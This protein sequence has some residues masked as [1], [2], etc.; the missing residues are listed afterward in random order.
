VAIRTAII[1]YG[2]AGRIFHAPLVQAAEGLE[3][4]AVSTSRAEQVPPGIRVAPPEALITDPAIELIVVAS[5][6]ET[7]FP[8]AKAALEAGKHVVVDKPMCV[9]TNEARTLIELAKASGRLLIPFHNRRWDSDF[10][11]VR[12]LIDSGK[13]GRVLLYEAHW[14]RFRPKVAERWREKPRPGAGLLFDLGPHMIDQALLLFG[15]PQRTIADLAAQRQGSQV[16]DYFALTL[17]YGA[18]RV[19]LSASSLVARPRPRFSIHGTEASFIMFG[20]DPQEDQLKAEAD[21]LAPGFGVDESLQG[22]LTTADGISS[23]VPSERGTWLNFYR[24]VAAALAGRG[25]PPVMPEDALAA[26]QIIEHAHAHQ[27]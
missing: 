18:S 22:T 8:L 23:A 26:L 10:L 13:L 24:G 12:K 1:G 5:P 7:H 25:P 19:L 16:D 3:L 4:A 15:T 6:N 17:H 14:D 9:S 27:A 21:V 2:L 20:L 11:T